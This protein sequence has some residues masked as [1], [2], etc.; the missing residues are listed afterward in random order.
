M[1]RGNHRS[2]STPGASSN[3]ARRARPRP[4]GV[5]AWIPAWM[6]GW[7]NAAARAAARRLGREPSY[8]APADM[9]GDAEIRDLVR[10]G[11]RAL[12]H[13]HR[14][15]TVDLTDSH[16]MNSAL[17]AG[18][19]LLSR[20]ARPAGATLKLVGY[21]TQFDSLMRVYKIWGPLSQAGVVLEPADA[22]STPTSPV[23]LP[24]A[25]P[26]ATA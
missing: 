3:A 24:R 4:R 15:L 2:D 25:T 6:S 13:G 18:I 5:A 1:D 9:T 19:V 7:K 23:V 12:E 26:A 21:S 17:L 10:W 16:A 20:R 8:R 22:D 14:T 11:E